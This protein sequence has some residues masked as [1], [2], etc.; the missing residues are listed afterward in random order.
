MPRRRVLDVLFVLRRTTRRRM[1]VELTKGP[2]TARAISERLNVPIATA[3]ANLRVL[4]EHGLVVRG[5]TGTGIA[6][7]LGAEVTV[8]ACADAVKI[9]FSTPCNGRFEVELPYPRRDVAGA[10]R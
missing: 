10:R 7:R 8:F 9:T 4:E 6:F 3:R 5:K 2:L 1:L